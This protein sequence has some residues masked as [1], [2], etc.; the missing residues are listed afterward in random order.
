MIKWHEVNPSNPLRAL[1]TSTTSMTPTTLN[2]SNDLSS[3]TIVCDPS[4]LEY[5]SNKEMPDASLPQPTFTNIIMIE[6]EK[7]EAIKK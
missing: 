5:E 2:T 6:A 3:N 4:N 1:T 7:I